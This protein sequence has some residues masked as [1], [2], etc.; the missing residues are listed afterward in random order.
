MIIHASWEVKMY[1]GQRSDFT[2]WKQGYI[3][4]PSPY[5]ILWNSVTSLGENKVMW[6]L[7]PLLHCISQLGENKG[8]QGLW[9]SQNYITSWLI[10]V[11]SL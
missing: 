6:D 4:P 9:V 8:G 10:N 7:S 11:N 5:F 1:S 2:R 3:R